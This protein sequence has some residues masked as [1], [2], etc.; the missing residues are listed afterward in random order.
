MPFSYG[1]RW[2]YDPEDLA[3]DAAPL[4]LASHPMRDSASIVFPGASWL[5]Q[6]N[7]DYSGHVLFAP[8]EQNEIP[9][10][11]RELPPLSFDERR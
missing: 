9:K 3:S 11:F 10:C 5:A 8:L 6:P 7:L 4:K 2:V 1:L